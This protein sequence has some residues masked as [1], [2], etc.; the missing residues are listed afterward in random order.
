MSVILISTH[1]LKNLLRMQQ[2]KS[3]HCLET[4]TASEMIHRFR[5]AKPTSRAVR[6]AMRYNGDAPKRLW[7]EP[8]MNNSTTKT[9]QKIVETAIE[10]HT[11]RTLLSSNSPKNIE[12]EDDNDISPLPTENNIHYHAN[13]ATRFQSK[14]LPWRKR[15]RFSLQ[16]KV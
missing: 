10:N 6:E 13:C 1:H 8:S 3:S 2:N 16:D 7:Y 9:R 4:A 11:L 15:F 12:E 14:M 5:H